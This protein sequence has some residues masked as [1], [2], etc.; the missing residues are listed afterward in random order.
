MI[1][2]SGKIIVPNE[3]QPIKKYLFK[4][5][6]ILFSEILIALIV[7][8]EAYNCLCPIKINSEFAGYFSKNSTHC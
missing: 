8:I 1:I 2:G 7:I 6:Q 3:A 4:K 5:L